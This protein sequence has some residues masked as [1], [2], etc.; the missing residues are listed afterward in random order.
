MLPIRPHVV[1]PRVAWLV[2]NLMCLLPYFWLRK[3]QPFYT[4]RLTQVLQHMEERPGH[5][6]RLQ[7]TLDR[8]CHPL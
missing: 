4:C 3:M 8:A 7:E 6:A 5:A 1:M 2:W